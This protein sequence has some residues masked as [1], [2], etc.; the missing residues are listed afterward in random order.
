MRYVLTIIAALQVAPAGAT[1]HNYIAPQWNSHNTLENPF[2]L[3]IYPIVYSSPFVG[4]F[5]PCGPTTG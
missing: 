2:W 1:W 3:Y 5:D 4:G